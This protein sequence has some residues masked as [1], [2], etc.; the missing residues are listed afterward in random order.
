MKC[1][2]I[3]VSV[4]LLASATFATAATGIFGGY[5]TIAGTKYKSN[6]SYGGS[7]PTFNG[8]NLGMQS[9][10][11]TLNLTQFET[12]AFADSGHSTFDFAF[13]Y[14]IR[15]NSLPTSTNPADY[16]FVSANNGGTQHGVSIGGNNEKAEW[17]G[18]VNLLSGLSNGAYAIDVIHKAGA[19]EGGSNFE[20]LANVNNT[21]PGSTSWSS[22]SPFSATFTVVPET[23]TSLLAALGTLI[24]LRRRR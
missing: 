10:G 18:A 17:T 15:L 12:L 4:T 19:W 5:L 3:I 24:L 16:A 8:L 1:A 13:A 2:P 23:T 21:Q 6:G 7:E 20:R 22:V 11:G 14:R 9:A